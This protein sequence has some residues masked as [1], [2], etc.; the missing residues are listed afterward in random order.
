MPTPGHDT[1]MQSSVVDMQGDKDFALTKDPSMIVV[2]NKVT[3]G[4]DITVFN[5]GDVC[6]NYF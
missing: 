4:V 6:D 5:L 3:G 2:E 1:L